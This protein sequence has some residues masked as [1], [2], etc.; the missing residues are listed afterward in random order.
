MNDLASRFVA[1]AEA[2]PEQPALVVDGTT[3]SYASLHRQ[4]ASLASLIEGVDTGETL[5]CAVFGERSLGAY[6]GILGILLAGRGYVPLNPSYPPDRVRTM[7]ERSGART[8]VVDG[9]SL[10]TAGE[11]LADVAEPLTIIVADADARPS[12]AE[13]SRHSVVLAGS[14]S[15]AP[16]RRVGEPPGP[17]AIAYLLFTSGTTG[18]PKGIG[19]RQSSVSAYLT[20]MGARLELG[21]GDRCTQNF[22]LTFDLSVHDLFVTWSGGACLCVPPPRSAMAPARFVRDE[23]V[24]AWFSTPT[25]AALMLRMRML[26]AN[27]FPSLRWSLF[28]GE[29]LTA[30]IADAWRDAAPNAVLENLYGPTECTIACTAFRHD[31]PAAGDL[32]NGV[33]PIG[34]PF[35]GTR[36]AIVDDRLMPVEAGGVGELLLGG[37]QLASGYWRDPERTA[38]AFATVPDLEPAAPWYRTGDLVSLAPDG[39]LIY[40]GRRDDQIKVRGHRVELQEVEAALRDA[41]GASSVVALGW[42]RTAAGADGIIAFVTGGNR[43]ER[44]ILETCRARLPEY[45]IPSEVTLVDS[46]PTNA[47]GKVDR[48]RLL[49]LRGASG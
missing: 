49:E 3:H 27:A 41:S 28:C 9:R 6:A 13:G 21:P 47:S 40:R 14:A 48:R 20:A 36:V 2:Y 10:E 8:V 22:A 39:D 33:L 24:T 42:P 25:T 11:S 4:A 44:A 32:V 26:T 37:D 34:R 29:A 7:L 45:M 19:I 1:S 5:L 46:M 16:I 38:S 43:D 30:D 15:D 17:E 18:I 31:G 23:G 12:W 35:G